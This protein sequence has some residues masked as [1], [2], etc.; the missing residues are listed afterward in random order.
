M[1]YANSL[2]IRVLNLKTHIYVIEYTYIHI[3][4]FYIH[5]RSYKCRSIFV[6]RLLQSKLC[7]PLG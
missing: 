6:F 4:I 5:S 3:K 7:C 1:Y 2:I